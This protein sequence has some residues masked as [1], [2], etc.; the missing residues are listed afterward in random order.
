MQRREEKIIDE[1]DGYMNTITQS[2]R[3]NNDNECK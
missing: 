2:R 1:Q 3:Q